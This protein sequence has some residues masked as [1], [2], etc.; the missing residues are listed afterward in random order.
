MMR[1]IAKLAPLFLVLLSNLLGFGILYF[2]NAELDSTVLY[3]SLAVLLIVLF[4]YAVI[5]FGSF[6]DEYLFLV[7]SMIFTIG[8]MFL[9]RISADVA[10]NQIL[11]FYI[12]MAGF[13]V[14][15]VFYKKQSF[16]HRPK[17]IMWYILFS[18]LLFMV[19][20]LFGSSSGGAKNWLSLG[21]IGIQPSEIIKIFFILA[22]SGLYTL[23]YKEDERRRGLLYQWMASPFKRQ[24]MIMVIAYTFLGFLVLQREWGS[25]V[26]YFLIYF[27]MQYVFGNSKSVFIINIFGAGAGAFLGIKTMTHIQERISI[28]LDPFQD[29]GSLGYQIVQ[30]L[31]AMA[32]GG[33]TGTGLG[34]GNPSFVPLVKNDFIFVAICEEF[35]MIGAIGVVMLFFLL[36]YRGIKISLRATNPFNKAVA[37]GLAAMFGY[38]TF[39]IIGGVTKF[40]PMTG[41]TLPFVSAG[42]SSLAACFVALGILQAISAKESENSDVI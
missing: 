37:L 13:F 29:P 33:F 20:L 10:Q 25:A 35:G 8:I 27:T 40:I 36:M 30:S 41:I 26:L 7:V 28:W 19:T 4:S 22:L 34:M 18:I 23:P 5:L 2:L 9:L 1:K 14:T 12:G 38:Q 31:Y 16:F 39:I 3:S 24:M 32:S 15:Y 11:Y 6:G 21:P 42:G 17:M